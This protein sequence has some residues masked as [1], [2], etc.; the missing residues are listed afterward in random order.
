MAFGARK[1]HYTAILVF[2]RIFVLRNVLT[3][4]SDLGER[5]FGERGW[6]GG[7]EGGEVGSWCREKVKKAFLPF[8]TRGYARAYYELL[9]G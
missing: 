3:K 7:G 2:C 4:V 5:R 9:Q 1:E 8:L 6:W